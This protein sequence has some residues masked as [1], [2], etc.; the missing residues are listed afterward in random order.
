MSWDDAYKQ[1]VQ[2]LGRNTRRKKPQSGYRGVW[3]EKGSNKYRAKI[4]CNNKGYHLGRFDTAVAAAKA[5]DKAAREMHGE[6]ASTN[7]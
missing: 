1:L 2:E 3:L 6:F 5:Y 4:W 7:F